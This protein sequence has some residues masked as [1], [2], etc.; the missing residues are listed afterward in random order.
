MTTNNKAINILSKTRKQILD[1][2]PTVIVATI[3]A[4]GGAVT[5]ILIAQM[6]DNPIWKLAKDPAQ[7]IEFE[8]YIGML[9]NWGALLWMATA[10]ICLFSAIVLKKY[11]SPIGPW[12]FIFIS[13][14]LSF[15]LAIDDLFL[16][17]DEVLPRIFDIRESFFYLL[18]LVLIISYLAFFLRQIQ[19]HD[20]ILFWFA[21]FLLAF[22]R[23]FFMLLPFLKEFKTAGDMLKYFG[24]VFWLAFFYRTALQ[25][26]SA[27]IEKNK[28]EFS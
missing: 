6:T 26:I 20:Y 18:Y 24:I 12:R 5:T 28:T 11:N 10:V 2:L 21:I 22:S 13:G 25:E 14:I 9:S 4:V 15:M 27:L 8:P 1:I 19:Q 17:H 16:L 7:V 3:I 23:R